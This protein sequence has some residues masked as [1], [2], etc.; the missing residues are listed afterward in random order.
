MEK[1]CTGIDV[2]KKSFKVCIMSRHL[3]HKKVIG[4]RTFTNSQDGFLA[5]AAW[6]SKK[7]KDE[8]VSYVMEATGSYHERLAYLTCRLTCRQFVTGG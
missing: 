6:V 5:L 2:D 4:S 1:Y 8:K 7:I 3:D